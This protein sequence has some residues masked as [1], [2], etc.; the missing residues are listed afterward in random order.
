MTERKPKITTIQGLL[1]LGGRQSAVGRS[2]EGWL[3]TGM[4][5]RMMMDVGLHL[6]TQKLVESERLTPADLE[7][8]KRPYLSTYIWDKTLSLSLGRPPL[9]TR[10]PYAIN[11][12]LDD[13][14]D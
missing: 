6:D 10:L 12:M 1:I 4:A 5:I 11:D 3:Y 2:S 7:A 13:L 14:D 9:L 8:R